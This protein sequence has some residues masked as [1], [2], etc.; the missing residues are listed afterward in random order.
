MN[1]QLQ[2]KKWMKLE[3][4]SR[5]HYPRS[6]PGLGLRD[7]EKRTG[8]EGSSDFRLLLA[9]RVAFGDCGG[10]S[11]MTS[12]ADTT[13]SKP[14]KPLRLT[15]FPEPFLHL[16][17]C[18]SVCCLRR[19]ARSCAGGTRFAGGTPEV[20]E[21]E[22]VGECALP[23]CV[24]DWERNTRGETRADTDS[25]GRD[26][27]SPDVLFSLLLSDGRALADRDCFKG[28]GARGLPPRCR[29]EEAPGAPAYDR[30]L[31]KEPLDAPSA[32][33][34]SVCCSWSVARSPAEG[35]P[36][37]WARTYVGGLVCPLNLRVAL[38]SLC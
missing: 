15:P 9:E 38:R 11:P 32:L 13:S 21:R 14:R 6:R 33:T 34:H 18:S 23:C 8:T 4:P 20:D 26:F 7:E 30:A 1:T 22:D 24:S 36:W 37:V 29:E 2:A 28:A 10:L 27:L 3:S 16:R 17:V 12:R 25:K 35:E 5:S 31:E 19:R